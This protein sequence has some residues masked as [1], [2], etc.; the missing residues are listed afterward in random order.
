MLSFIHHPVTEHLD[1]VRAFTT[2][3]ECRRMNVIYTVSIMS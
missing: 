1:H 3:D 2:I